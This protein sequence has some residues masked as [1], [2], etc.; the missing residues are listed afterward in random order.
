MTSAGATNF[1]RDQHTSQLQFPSVLAFLGMHALSSR[2]QSGL[3]NRCAKTRR[4]MKR[5]REFNYFRLKRKSSRRNSDSAR[6]TRSK[7]HVRSGINGS[8]CNGPRVHSL[9]RVAEESLKM[10]DPRSCKVLPSF[11]GP[12]SAARIRNAGRGSE[13]I[14]SSSIK[15]FTVSIS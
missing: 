15:D 7:Q 3:I 14:L 13:S 11:Q 10:L 6:A 9:P 8:E 1:L 2:R 4:P 12:R 5:A